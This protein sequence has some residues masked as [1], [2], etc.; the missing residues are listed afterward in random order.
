MYFVTDEAIEKIAAQIN[1]GQVGVM[2]TDTIYGLVASATMPEVVKYIYEVKKRAKHKKLIKLISNYNQLSDIGITIS[3][4]QLTSL[5]SLW[6]GPISVEL[7]SADD[8]F[9]YLHLGTNL[10]AV[11]MP[12][13]PWLC[14]LLELTGPIVATS[15]NI[16]GQPAS[17]SLEQ[18]RKELPGLDFYIE[19]KVGTTPSKLVSVSS[20]GQITWLTRG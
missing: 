6:P 14:Q 9:E 18:V 19:G 11:R 13:L 3:P 5:K 15:A 4:I 12:Q 20:D 7:F 10:Q 17:I 1:A 8:N 16:S 2:P